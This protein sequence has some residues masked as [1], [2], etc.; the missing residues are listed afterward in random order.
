M[1]FG[2]SHRRLPHLG[3]KV[4][5]PADDVLREI[6]GHNLDGAEIG[7][8]AFGEFVYAWNDPR[9]V[10]ESWMQVCFP[11]VVPRFNINNLV[12]RRTLVFA[13]A[14]FGKSNLNK[15]LFSYLYRETPTVEKRGGR[16]APVG[17]IIFDP[18]GE[19]FWPDDISKINRRRKW[20]P[21]GPILRR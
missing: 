3:S 14:G 20:R 4:A 9:Y 8:L 1:V 12:S 11:Q 17:T 6:A 2:P 16:R 19:Y 15:L 7:H 10:G 18:E 5:F 13:R 21:P